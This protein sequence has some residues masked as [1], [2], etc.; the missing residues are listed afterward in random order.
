MYQMP[1][2]EVRDSSVPVIGDGQDETNCG[3]DRERSRPV[4]G[5]QQVLNIAETESESMI[6]PYTTSD[7]IR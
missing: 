6:E 2:S 7:D 5:A 3:S 4:A 1:W